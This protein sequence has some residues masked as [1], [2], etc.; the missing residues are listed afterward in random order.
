MKKINLEEKLNRISYRELDESESLQAWDRISARVENPSFVERLQIKKKNM[1]PL[2]IGAL[3]FASAGGTVAASNNAVPGDVLFGVDRAVENVRIAFAGNGKAELKLKFAEERLEEVERIIAE[4]RLKARATSTATTTPSTG[5]TTATTTPNSSDDRMALGVSVA[6]NYLNEISAD[7]QA[8]GSTTTVR[9]LESAIDRLE[10]IAN[11]DDVKVK[12]KKNGAFQLKLQ[13][14][15][16]STAS[17]TGS[18]KINT[19]GN[20]DRIEIRE[21]GER[22]RIELKDSGDLKVKVKSDE[23]DSEPEIESGDSKEG[24]N[25][26][27]NKDKEDNKDRGNVN[28]SS[29]LR[30]DLR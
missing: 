13:G 14:V 21:D 19:N 9:A 22:I 28:A 8:S 1:I 11:T 20:K 16:S 6:L 5:T 29:S 18:V 15:A 26:D 10:S 12:L 3:I 30:I 25:D 23:D 4:A 2:I 7:L 27:K 24:R 17:S